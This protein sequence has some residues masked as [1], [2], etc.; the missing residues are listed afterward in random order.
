MALL[1]LSCSGCSGLNEEYSVEAETEN[2]GWVMSRIKNNQK[3]YRFKIGNV[4]LVICGYR[5]V[6]KTI[7][8]GGPFIPFIPFI[9]IFYDHSNKNLAVEFAVENPGVDVKLNVQE[10]RV[11]MPDG[12]NV[13]PHKPFSC[14]PKADDICDCFLPAQVYRFPDGSPR[15]IDEFLR[16]AR[17]Y[18]KPV[19]AGLIPVGQGREL[20]K[21]SYP[22]IGRAMEFTI[23]FG[24]I[25]V[26]G[27]S[28]RLDP[29]KFKKKFERYEY[30]PMTH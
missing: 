6:P 12:R 22:E 4:S 14:V 26:G 24:D 19:E 29:L 7:L 15:P 20:F 23:V 2:T 11:E 13:H 17:S 3:I 5:N 30:I 21:L 8:V 1:S 9:P 28:I 27:K 25:F 16:M 18:R 10:I